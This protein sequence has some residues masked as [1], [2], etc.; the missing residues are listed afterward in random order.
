MK[1]HLLCTNHI[2]SKLIGDILDKRDLNQ[3][4][5]QEVEYA[6]GQL[7]YQFHPNPETQIYSHNHSVSAQEGGGAQVYSRTRSSVPP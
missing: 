3:K 1:K 6:S 7:Q 2:F 5:G 4:N